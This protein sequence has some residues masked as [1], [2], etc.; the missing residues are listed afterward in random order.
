MVRHAETLA[1]ELNIETSFTQTF[2]RPRNKSSITPFRKLL[3][4]AEASIA[5]KFRPLFDR[6]L[7]KRLDAVKQSKGGI[8][9]PESASKKILEATVVA[10]GPG[11]RNQD[12]KP[13]P[14]DVKVGDR[15]LLPE[16]GGT[17]IQLD[18]DDSYTIFKESELLAKV[19]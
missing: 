17:K 9:L 6:V 3:L 10:V 13:I 16:Y 2:I 15:V 1:T 14:I 8:M 5:T 7:V 12:G 18:D 19:E 4:K 11:A